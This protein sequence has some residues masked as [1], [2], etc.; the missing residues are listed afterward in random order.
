M[1]TTAASSSRTLLALEDPGA[2]DPDV[3]GHKAATL[4]RLISEGFAVPRGVVLTRSACERIL[5]ASGLGP[6]APA[7]QVA[8]AAIPS[9]VRAELVASLASFD[10]SALAVR[11]S[12]I[13]E[14]LPG[15]S[16]AGQYETVLGVRGEDAL[17]DAVH[18]C[19]A[20]AFSER[21]AAYSGLRDSAA[22]MSVLI[23]EMVEADAAGVAFTANPVT[24]D[25]ETLVSAVRGLGERLVGGEASPDEWVVRH[26]EVECLSAPEDAIDSDDARRVADLAAEVEAAL[27]TPQDI[28]WAIAGGELFL[29]Q[30]RP[31]TALPR[32]PNIEVPSTGYWIKDDTHYPMPLTPFG[33]SVYLPALEVGTKPMFEEFGFLLEGFE[34]RSLGG[35]AYMRMIPIGGKDRKAPPWWVMWIAAR[36]APPIRKRARVAE[37]ALRTH[38]GDQLI[39]RWYAEWR[40]WL[41]QETAA[42]LSRDLPS[43]DDQGLLSHLGDAEELI[44]KGEYIHFV[45]WVAYA[46]PVYELDLACKE[47]LGWDP[48]QTLTLVAGTSQASSAP[49]RALTELAAAVGRSLEAR[50]AVEQGGSDVLQ[51]LREAAPEV[52]VA[53]DGYLAEHG[54]RTLSYDPGDPTLAERPELLAGL[55]RDRLRGAA[56]G[57][58]DAAERARADALTRARA[59]LATRSDGE[60]ERFERALAAAERAYPIREDNVVWTDNVPS[61][62][63]RYS[64]VEFGRRLANRGA[65]AKADDAVF[66]EVDQLRAAL[67]GEH[68][69]LRDTVIRRRAE[70]AWVASHPGPASYGPDPGPPP[71]LRGLQPGVRHLMEGLMW[72]MQ[73]LIQPDRAEA[74]EGEIAGAPGSPGRHTGPVRVI[75]DESEFDRLRPGDVLVC[76]ITSPAWSVL[77]SQAGAVVTDGGGV[78]AH[79]AVIAREYG[80]PAVLATG[81]ATR[82]LRDGQVVTVDGSSGVIAVTGSG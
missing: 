3:A 29:L 70:R 19:L 65:L 5:S 24:G 78:L 41:R 76:P 38:R 64:A 1:S 62:I 31:I 43:L 25:E 82:R 50:Q 8:A 72:F 47:L 44:G 77:F 56:S 46:L 53:M 26:G 16:F 35:E 61:A 9:D 10:G 45:L 4:A 11:S 36:L 68:E 73:L 69:N 66:L 54:H 49:G 13:A 32:E 55:L 39:D 80:I 37:E 40:P 33:A 81:D 79:A 7:E 28:E 6:D 14:D 2:R 22:P 59:E 57:D 23:Q 52:A 42:L 63:L 71:D 60:R 27:G 74:R 12:G 17:V 20:S 51:R 75:R 30:A 34:Q 15:A 67:L 18:R 48:L 58:A 21:V